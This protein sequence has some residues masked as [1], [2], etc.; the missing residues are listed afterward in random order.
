MQ[1]QT[2][3]RRRLGTVK[4]L[5]KEL[6]GALTEP[7]IRDHVYR[8]EERNLN[9]GRNLPANGLAPAIIKIGS[10]VLIDFD[11]Y[12]AWLESHRLAPR[13]DLPQLRRDL[14]GESAAA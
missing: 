11:L 2:N 13:A 9:N 12:F 14:T 1:E 5:Y 3:A 6:G 4:Q 8:A 10:K 7:A